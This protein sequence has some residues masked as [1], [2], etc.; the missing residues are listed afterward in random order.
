[1]EQLISY[2]L[3]LN[4]SQADYLAA[5]KYGVN[6]M[7]ALVSL[8]ELVKTADEEYSIK[9][10]S[11][12]LKVGQFAASEVEL[13]HLWKCDRK[14]VSRLLDQMNELGLRGLSQP[15]RTTGRA[16]TPCTASRTGGSRTVPS[17]TS[18]LRNRSRKA[19]SDYR[20]SASPYSSLPLLPSREADFPNRGESVPYR[21]TILLL[22]HQALE[23]RESEDRMRESERIPPSVQG[24]FQTRLYVKPGRL[25]KPVPGSSGYSSR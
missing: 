5:S 24:W 9:G 10:F 18:S 11:T 2:Q 7:Q 4:K 15:S 12:Q 16:S 13:S 22:R 3:V 21:K 20:A 17:T 6:R 8:L 19:I 14:T 25:R 1:M 23:V